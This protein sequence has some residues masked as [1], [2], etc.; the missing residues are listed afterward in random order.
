MNESK[1]LFLF[2]LIAIFV[3]CSTPISSF[4]Y[5]G[6]EVVYDTNYKSTTYKYQGKV[7][8]NDILS[9][10]K[11]GDRYI[12]SSDYTLSKV[13]SEDLVDNIGKGKKYTF[14]YVGLDDAPTME[15]I[16]YV[17]DGQSYFLTEVFIKSSDAIKSNY[18][19]PIY[20]E[21]TNTFLTKDESNRAL[22]VP[23][24][25]DNFVH[26]FS[27]PF[28][29][30]EDTSSEVTSFFNGKERSGLVIGSVEH[31]NWKTGISYKISNTNE[32]DFLDCFGGLASALTRD[33]SDREDRP[34]SPHGSL[35][36]TSI[37]SPKMLVGFFDDWRRGME[38]FGEVNAI[39]APPRAWDGGTPFGWNSWAAMAEKVNYEGAIDVSEFFKNELQP[40]NFQNDGIVY[41]GLDSY[42]DNFTSDQLKQFVVEVNNNGQKAGIYWC[43]FSDW[44]GN[45]EAYVEGTNN[46]YK[47][48]DIYLYAENGKPKKIESIAVDPTH[49]GTKKRMD[50]F[51][52]MFKE[53]GYEYVKLDFINNGTIEAASF[54]NPKV[55]TGVQA[56]NEGMSYLSELAGKDMFFALSIAPTFPAQW[57]NSKRISC[58]AWG[59]MTEGE[60]GTTGYMLNSLSFGWWL[61]RVY[62]FNDAD[63]ILLYK[64]SEGDDYQLGSN[65]ARVTS[66]VITGLYMFGDNFSLKGSLKGDQEARDKAKEV[67]TNKEINEIAKIGKSFYPVEGYTAASAGKSETQFMLETE[68]C[69]YL[70]VF[71]FNTSENYE[72]EV[73]LERLGLIS[74]SDLIVKE[75]WTSETSVTE[76]G[77]VSYNVP[78]QDARVYKIER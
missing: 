32:I 62:P 7:I 70:A 45:A 14:L 60:W 38:T 37:K 39:I 20:T 55:T 58:D 23:F 12:S 54:H 2:A 31:D 3:S 47:Y 49:P 41:I 42:W 64:P 75:L 52:N 46:E 67:A 76:N 21:S 6:W 48:K 8:L 25:N 29:N 57:G 13:R 74:N 61:D 27:H 53:L 9:R 30:V 78:S 65:R 50:H 10:Y 11:L 72:G 71:N 36:G 24:D 66:A 51:I 26:Y 34:S 56:Y 5:Q 4:N 28:N 18:I 17:Y 19:S 63:H 43:P 15:Q 40:N 35:S 33:V 77:T 59:A 44:H 68:D 73:S 22:S 16:Y 69:L 1:V